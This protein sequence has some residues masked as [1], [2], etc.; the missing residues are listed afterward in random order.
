MD[1]AY[2]SWST[3][4]DKL[5]QVT[6]APSGWDGRKSESG[7][8]IFKHK[9]F[10]AMFVVKQNNQIR[11]LHKGSVS[12]RELLDIMVWYVNKFQSIES[13][14]SHT[15]GAQKLWLDFVDENPSMKY[16]LKDSRGNL[17]P[18]TSDK[19]QDQ[20]DSIWTKRSAGVVTIMVQK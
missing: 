9:H 20:K 17:T 11:F 3:A 13:D 1:A 6:A 14:F 16:F 4:F 10:G 15:R 19:I 7:D 2:Q 12:S 5:S 18:I 8:S